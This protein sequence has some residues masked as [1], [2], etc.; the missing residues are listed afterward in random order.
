[1]FTRAIVMFF[2]DGVQVSDELTS[3]T[4]GRLEINL[5]FYSYKGMSGASFARI[6]LLHNS[7]Q[8]ITKLVPVRSTYKITT[9]LYWYRE[10]G[11]HYHAH[12]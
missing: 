1:M 4:L 10:G 12:Q 9:F 2:S 8:A 7:P 6:V 3:P 11:R 5:R